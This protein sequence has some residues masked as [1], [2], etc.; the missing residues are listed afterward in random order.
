MRHMIE[1]EIRTPCHLAQRKTGDDIQSTEDLGDFIPWVARQPF[2]RAFTRED[3]LLPVG[4]HPACKHEEGGAGGV[5]HRCFCGLNQLRVHVQRIAGTKFLDDGRLGA[6]VL[7]GTLGGAEFIE[8]RIIDTDGVSIDRFAF[9][10]AGHGHD[11]AGV[12]TAGEVGTHGHIGTQAPVHGLQQEVLKLIHQLGGIRLGVFFALIREIHLPVGVLLN[13]L[14]L[15]GGYLQIM[16]CR[17]KLDAGKAG[18]RAGHGAKGE[19]VIYAFQIRLCIDH[20]R[21][22][23]SFDLRSKQQPVALPCPIQWGDAKAIAPEGELMT[24]HIIQGHGKLAAHALKHAFMTLLPEMRDD[25]GV[26]VG[27][28][29][30]AARDQRCALL[31]KIKELAVVDGEGALVFIAHG[32]LAI[33]KADDAQAA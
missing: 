9:E 30:M 23:Q 12:K 28:Q 2:I 11:H 7:G 33:G 20:S 24:R 29:H 13:G 22:Q 16:T 4:V 1:P 3:D 26:A 17:Q 10:L 25:L 14:R 32:L 6:D 21:S 19:D 31:G 15:T 8:L 5:D 18:R 27:V